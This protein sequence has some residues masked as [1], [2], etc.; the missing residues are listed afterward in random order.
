MIKNKSCEYPLY[1]DVGEYRE[2]NRYEAVLRRN[3]A[4]NIFILVLAISFW[5]ITFLGFPDF[6]QIQKT[7]LLLTLL[8][9]WLLA[10]LYLPLEPMGIWWVLYYF[11]CL[12]LLFAWTGFSTVVIIGDSG[13]LIFV[14]CLCTFAFYFFHQTYKAR[15]RFIVYRDVIDLGREFYKRDRIVSIERIDKVILDTTNQEIIIYLR[16][17]DTSYHV[18][19]KH[20]R[21]WMDL[22]KSLEEIGVAYEVVGDISFP[23]KTQRK[24]IRKRAKRLHVTK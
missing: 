13:G 22:K 2:K 8:I 21:N 16:G 17:T 11:L 6:Y 19:K 3:V 9:L 18:K 24:N 14:A 7:P 1:D 4:P 20:K 23:D 10:F 5:I 12:P 15:L